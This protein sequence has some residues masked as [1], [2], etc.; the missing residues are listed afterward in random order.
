MPT[1]IVETKIYTAKYFREMLL[2]D[3]SLDMTYISAGEF[4]MGAPD[5]EEGS[6]DAER[7]QHFVKVPHFFLGKYPITQDQYL[8]V[9]DKNPSSFTDDFKKS[10]DALHRPVENV[11]WDNAQKFCERLRVMTE[12]PYRLP[13][14]AEWEYACR[15]VVTEEKGEA[16]T[17]EIWNRKYYQP[18]HFGQTISDQVAN[19]DATEVY[20]V[21]KEGEYREQ[22]TPV[23]LLGVAN[24]FGL[25]D[26]HG[27]V[28]EWCEDEYLGDHERMMTDDEAWTYK[29]HEVKIRRG[30]SFFAAPKFCRSAFRANDFADVYTSSLGFR[31]AVSLEGA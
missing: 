5:D 28:S 22:T 27:N 24:S 20:G 13:T 25:Y 2:G 21:G 18:F 17:K 15:G 8:A 9:M 6:G 26:M 3:V 12:K 29:S 31:V 10:G 19:Y 4:W 1:L 16:L 11:S 23:G 14:E 7:P 30:G